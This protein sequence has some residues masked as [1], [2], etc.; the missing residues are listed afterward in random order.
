MNSFPSS[1]PTL[2]S[3]L[4]FRL[5]HVLKQINQEDIHQNLSYYDDIDNL[6]ISLS[7]PDVNYFDYI[8]TF[9]PSSKLH[10]LLTIWNVN[11]KNQ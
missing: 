7:S 11:I 2:F 9:T 6:H 8:I 4:S 5:R 3:S 10:L 1:F